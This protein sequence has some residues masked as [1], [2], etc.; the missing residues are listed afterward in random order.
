MIC[1]IRGKGIDDSVYVNKI[2]NQVDSLLKTGVN[3]KKIL[4][5]GASSGRS[6]VLGLSSKLKM[7]TMKY[8]IMGGCRPETYKDYLNT[9]LYGQFLSVI[10]ATDPHGTCYMIFDKRNHVKDYQ[11]I[12]LHTGLSHGFIYKGRKEWIE[13]IVHWF[14]RK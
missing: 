14:E 12:T 5:V 10:E 4:I 1:E 7:E 3:T 2:S 6:I 13:P 8:V 9:E 11:E